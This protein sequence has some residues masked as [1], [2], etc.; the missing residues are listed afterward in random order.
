MGSVRSD[1]VGQRRAVSPGCGDLPRSLCLRLASASL[2][3]WTRSSPPAS[4]P[5]R[6]RCARPPS[7]LPGW[8]PAREGDPRG[9]TRGLRC[10]AAPGGWG[11]PRS[12]PLRGGG[13]GRPGLAGHL[14]QVAAASREG[15]G[16]TPH[17][18]ASEA[19]REGRRH[20]WGDGGRMSVSIY[21]SYSKCH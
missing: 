17:L 14:R 6:R 21:F 20:G 12:R 13:W 1:H 9:G 11:V 16:P 15:L 19:W 10:T 7:G 2:A 5:T 18:L 4:R 3:A 8:G